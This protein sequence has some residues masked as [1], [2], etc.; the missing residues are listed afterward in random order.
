MTRVIGTDVMVKV[1]VSS[2]LTV[3]EYFG[4]FGSY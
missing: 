1:R 3:S 2:G 4:P